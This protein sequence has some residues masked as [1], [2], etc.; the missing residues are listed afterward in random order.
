M[1]TGVIVSV[2]L[3]GLFALSMKYQV[4]WRNTGE[5]V[6][7]TLWS[8]HLF[9]RRY[10]VANG[11][12]PPPGWTAWRIPQSASLWRPEAVPFRP[13]RLYWKSGAFELQLPLWILFVIAASATVVLWWRDRPIPPGHCQHCG[14]NLTGNV[15][16][17]C[18]ECGQAVPR[19]EA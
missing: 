11:L 8:G 9:Y 14:Y 16:G 18:P 5:S 15:S 17:R 12:A 19:T 4:D 13:P 2:L 3:I 10:P 7:V 1:W 6:R